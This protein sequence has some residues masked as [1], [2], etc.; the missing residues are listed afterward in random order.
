[1]TCLLAT[2]PQKLVVSRPVRGPLKALSDSV[3]SVLQ[4]Y[5]KKIAKRQKARL[6]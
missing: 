2:E 5:Y 1:M 6:W 3:N 4:F